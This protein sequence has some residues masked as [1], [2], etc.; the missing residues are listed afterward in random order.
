M[1]YPVRCGEYDY[2]SSTSTSRQGALIGKALT[3]HGITGSRR[4]AG[5]GVV[6]SPGAQIIISTHIIQFMHTKRLKRKCL[7][8]T[9]TLTLSEFPPVSFGGTRSQ[10]TCPEQPTNVNEYGIWVSL[11]RIRL[12]GS[13]ERPKESV[14]NDGCSRVS[15][16]IGEHVIERVGQRR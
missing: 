1:Y 16:A 13:V 14:E 15:E 10:L 4:G 8:L 7:T 11:G 2:C 12:G 5:E 6:S 9:L 3:G